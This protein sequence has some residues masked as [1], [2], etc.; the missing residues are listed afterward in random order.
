MGNIM[1]PLSATICNNPNF[2]TCVNTNPNATEV[3]SYQSL[4]HNGLIMFWVPTVLTILF[5]IVFL[6][7]I[8][9]IPSGI[10]KN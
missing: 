6:P 10:I 1:G 8:G 4:T 2:N 5:Y 7:A 9:R 3:G